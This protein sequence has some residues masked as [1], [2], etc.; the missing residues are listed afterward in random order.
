MN[1]MNEMLK[2]TRA[3]E[4]AEARGD[5]LL[6]IARAWEAAREAKEHAD[7]A[8]AGAWC[9]FGSGTFG[10]L[11]SHATQEGA[12]RSYRVQLD[13]GIWRGLLRSSGMKRL[14]G[15]LQREGHEKGMERDEDVAHADLEG[16]TAE[17][18]AM[19]ARADEIFART[20][21]HLAKAL[22]QEPGP[23]KGRRQRYLQDAEH[24]PMY[25]IDIEING[26][27]YPYDHA[28]YARREDAEAAKARLE[29]LRP[30]DTFS[31]SVIL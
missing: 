25:A 22:S 9:T 14:M 6:A 26:S 13:R 19:T 3:H 1:E 5:A 31:I 12:L 15:R 28:R 17:L 8:L 29:Q 11:R 16:I 20:V 7:A 18:G 24:E 10:V 2:R 27:L 23:V 21:L 30:H 4:I